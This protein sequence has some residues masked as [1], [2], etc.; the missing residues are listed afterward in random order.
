MTEE[1]Q[2]RGR[3]NDQKGTPLT[4]RLQQELLDELDRMR[5]EEDDL[6]TRPEMLRRIMQRMLDEQQVQVLLRGKR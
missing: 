4:V 1:R 6:P 5:K 3:Q 2:R